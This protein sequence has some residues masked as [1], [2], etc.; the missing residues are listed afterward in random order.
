MQSDRSMH[1]KGWW[2]FLELAVVTGGLNR[3]T[4]I[5]L[6]FGPRR[7]ALPRANE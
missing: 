4:P 2:N 3:R 5:S 7:I 6:A 1:A